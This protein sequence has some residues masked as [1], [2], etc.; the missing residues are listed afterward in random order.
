MT[1]TWTIDG[2]KVIDV[3]ED[4]ERVTHLEVSLVGGDLDVVT[5]TD[6]PTAR[7]EVES[8]EGAPLGVDW[9]GSR[10]R[11][12][13][14]P[15]GSRLAELWSA[16]GAAGFFGFL[17]AR[18][19]GIERHQARVSIS[20]PAECEVKVRT[21]TASALVSGIAGPVSIGTVSGG[22]SVDDVRGSVDANTVSGD[23]ECRDLRGSLRVNA[24]SGAVTAQASDLPTVRV[25]TVSGDIVLDLV[26]PR[27]QI[28]STSVSANVTV[29]APYT[30]FDL[31]ATSA[32]GHVVAGGQS[33]D[34][35]RSRADRS[36]HIREGDGGM[37]IRATAVSGDIVL[38]PGAVAGRETAR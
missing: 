25:T 8:V 27:A 33:Y 15:A 29:R 13:H 31:S 1:Q 2:P 22:L 9:D 10:L 24:V 32:S 17:G 36:R 20:V 7:V 6:S 14:L 16:H 35:R 21:V 18:L 23:V 34:S 3:G 38:L 37:R 5:H 11:V 19:S 26:N 28:S 30:G 12:M 4:G